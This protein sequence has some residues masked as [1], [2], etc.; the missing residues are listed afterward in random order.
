MRPTRPSFLDS[1]SVH[2]LLFGGK[3]GVGK[4]TCAV[5]AAL[6]LATERAADS[7]LLVSTD[8]AHSLGDSLAGLTP[9]ANL[10][11][12]ELDAQQCLA[13]FRAENGPTL[14][15][16]AAAGTFLDDEDIRRFL[17]L[18]L[19]GLDE[20]M[21][22]L[23]IADRVAGGR[24]AC[25]V[26][27]TAPSG[28]TLRLLGMPALLG[29]WLSMLDAL[30]AKRRYMRKVFGRSENPD[31]LDLFLRKWRRSLRC[32]EKL[33]T[34]PARCRFVPVTIAEP[35]SVRETAGLRKELERWRIPVSEVIVN[36]LH[37]PG[38]CATCSEAHMREQAQIRQLCPANGA[39]ALWAVDLFADEVR[40]AEMLSRF[41]RHTRLI[42]KAPEIVFKLRGTPHQRVETPAM[43]PP[44]Q[45]RLVLFA[46]KGGVGKTTLSCVTAV[47]LARD[48][49]EKRIL[50]FSTDPAHSLSACLNLEIGPR[51]VRVAAGLNAMEIDA[52]AE[53]EAL[54]ARYAAD[55]QEFLESV[56]GGLDLTFD[57]IVL[58]KMLDLA[59]PGLDEVMALARILDFLAHHRYDVFVLD[60]AATGH[61]IRLMELPALIDQWL[62]TFFSV[63]LKYERVW[64][65]PRFSGE[66]IELS[67]NLK[68]FR[69][70]LLDPARAI[71]YVVSIPTR[72]AWEETKD[73][74]AACDGLGI[75]VPAIFLNLM[76]P[77]GDCSL[78]ASLRRRE[79][80]VVRS[81]RQTFP[82]QQHSLIYRQGHP[83]GLERLDEL[84]EALYQPASVEFAGSYVPA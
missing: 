2:L 24:Y 25:I 74:V 26:V 8:P 78:C 53:F 44:R 13:A 32:M 61:F 19:P 29:N 9:P 81:F 42:E 75:V 40:G 1:S 33:L 80:S 84:A 73:L 79:L 23:Q 35:L 15:E 82:K 46:G 43:Q 21:A 12:L 16:I 68:Q 6:Q 67:K 63:L 49:P 55:I 59:P 36:Q 54:K 27:D 71:L 66:L 58:E 38:P 5:A 11:V 45:V 69:G 70:L 37:P 48:F 31:S 72:M 18:S 22:F 39:H 60:S 65:L 51:P 62:K 20:L 76:T 41:W 10:T 30:L 57:R 56:A 64:K 34:D 7:F 4:T 3:G 52:P 14:H 28:H 17:N 83:V 47:R 50:L 77:P